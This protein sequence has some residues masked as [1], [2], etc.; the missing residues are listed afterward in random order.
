LFAETFRC[1]AHRSDSTGC[2]SAPRILSK[3]LLG[4]ASWTDKSLVASGK[5]YPPTVKTPT[6]RLKFYATKFPIVEVDSSYY[7]IPDPRTGQLSGK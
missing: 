2:Q 6:D 4:T 1:F 7:G 5:V 3:I